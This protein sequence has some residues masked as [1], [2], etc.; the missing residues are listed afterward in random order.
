MTFAPEDNLST[1]SG[2]ENN[3]HSQIHAT[4]RISGSSQGNPFSFSQHPGSLPMGSVSSESAFS[5]SIFPE[6]HVTSFYSSDRNQVPGLI[7]SGTSDLSDNT[8]QTPDVVDLNSG[9]NYRHLSGVDC[10]ESL[11]PKNASSFAPYKLPGKM[12]PFTASSSVPMPQGH[13]R[14]PTQGRSNSTSHFIG[15]DTTPVMGTQVNATFPGLTSLGRSPFYGNPMQQPNGFGIS[16]DTEFHANHLQ[17]LSSAR[18]NS[19]LEKLQLPTNAT[20]GIDFGVVS[21][22]APFSL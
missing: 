8:F 13:A 16:H 6:G 2:M 7:S 10:S 18:S 22:D 5:P 1:T 11:L 12:L 14:H 20:Q 17:S 15:T 4:R 21:R 19:S 3:T 9:H